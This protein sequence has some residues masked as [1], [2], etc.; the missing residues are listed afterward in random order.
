MARKIFYFL[1]KLKNVRDINTIINPIS[2]K[3]VGISSKNNIPNIVAA[4]G[5][6]EHRIEAFP[7]SI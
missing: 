3:I 2:D 7:A 6:Q 4:T 5:S 1:S